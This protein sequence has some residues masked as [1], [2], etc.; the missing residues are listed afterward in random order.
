MGPVLET[1]KLTK[2]YG[3]SRGIIDVD[4]EIGEGEIFGFIGPNG[5]GMNVYLFELR[6]AWKGALVWTAV[7]LAF[8]VVMA[9][10]V[11]P[12]FRIAAPPWK[13]PLRASPGV[14]GGLRRI[15]G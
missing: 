5:A 13:P 11:Y 10:G 1:K 4:M 3:K 6:R 7:L 15:F 14:Q 9:E 2:Y 8:L 12:L